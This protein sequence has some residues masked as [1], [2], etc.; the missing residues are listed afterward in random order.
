MLDKRIL[1]VLQ[2]MRTTS[3]ADGAIQHEWIV[4]TFASTRQPVTCL[5]DARQWVTA[6][7]ELSIHNAQHYITRRL[8]FCTLSIML[9][10]QGQSPSNFQWQTRFQWIGLYT[11]W[12]SWKD[13]KARYLHLY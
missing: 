8:I 2:H 11:L 9:L 12:K 13:I 1:G 5:P 4:A 3:M 10:G 7:D 6:C